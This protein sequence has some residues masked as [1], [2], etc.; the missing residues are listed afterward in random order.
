MRVSHACLIGHTSINISI[1]LTLQC[2]ALPAHVGKL[3]MRCN[4]LQL[5]TQHATQMHL[6]QHT[7]TVQRHALRALVHFNL[8]IVPPVP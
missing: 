5:L 2:R 1:I 6:Q 8:S 3:A 7:T 4:H